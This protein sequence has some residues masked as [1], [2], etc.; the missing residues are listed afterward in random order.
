MSTA[1]ISSKSQLTVPKDVANELN[2]G[3]GD[4]VEFI[5]IGKGRFEIIASNKDV[6]ELRGMFKA[7]KAVSIDDMNDAIRNRGKVL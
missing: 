2:V 4:K 6:R 5:K 1:T 7:D 3:R